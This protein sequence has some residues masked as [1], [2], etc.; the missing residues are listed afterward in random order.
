MRKN[1]FKAQLSV[2]LSTGFLGGVGG[3]LLHVSGISEMMEGPFVKEEGVGP[4]TI[5]ALILVALLLIGA[6]LLLIISKIKLSFMKI[7]G[8]FSFF[9]ATFIVCLVYLYALNAPLN[10][11][12]PVS[13]LV[14]IIVLYLVTAHPLSLTTAAA[15]VCIGSLLGPLIASMVPSSSLLAMLI[16]AALYDIFSV[17]KGPLK[18]LLDQ[19]TEHSKELPEKKTRSSPLV[20][21][22]INLGD[23]AIGMGDIV[24]YSSLSSLSLT[25]PTLDLIRFTLIL[26]SMFIGLQLTFKL[27]EKYRYAPAL[28]LPITISVATYILYNL[29]RG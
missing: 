4:A 17:Y 1:V 20:P 27:L 21:F 28:P 23:A 13:L 16:A 24:F 3:F 6:L 29:V 25:T 19:F 11:P 12:E 15:Q 18:A 22:A 10:I 9:T 5:N 2:V 7:L 8:Y 26:V 14:A